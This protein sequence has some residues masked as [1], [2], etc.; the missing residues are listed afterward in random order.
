M[1]RELI[2]T[3]ESDPRIESTMIKAGSTYLLPL[4]S[5]SLGERYLA[6]ARRHSYFT[7]DE[8]STLPRQTDALF[9]LDEITPLAARPRA[10]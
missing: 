9:F 5:G 8:T 7:W 3:L 10:H 6:S 4:H 1:S 2:D